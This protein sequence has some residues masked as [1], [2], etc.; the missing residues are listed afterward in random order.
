MRA[1]GREEPLQRIGLSATQRPIEEIGR[2]LGGVSQPEGGSRPVTIVEAAGRQAARPPGGRAGRRPARPRDRPQA[3][4]ADPALAVHGDSASRRSIWPSIYPRVLEMVA[5]AQLDDRV[6]QQ[7]PP[8]RAAR[9][10]AERPRRGGGRAFPPRLAVARG[11][12]RDRGGAEVG[13]AEVPGRDA[14]RW[15]SASTWAPWTSSCRSSR[16][17]RLPAACSASAARATRSRR[18]R[19]AGCSRSSGPTWSS[20]R[21]SRS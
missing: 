11:A 9:A 19:R 18:S 7:P 13:A 16:R 2:F 14:A 1:D 21:W 5:R 17:S 4:A 10:A 6:R 12:H 3:D 20:A 8:G 15:S